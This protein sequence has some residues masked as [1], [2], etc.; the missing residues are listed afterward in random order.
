MGWLFSHRTRE[1]LIAER[2]EDV[3]TNSGTRTVLEHHLVDDVL[4]SLVRL[5]P[6]SSTAIPGVAAGEACVVIFCDLIDC[7]RGLWGSKTL[8]EGMGPFYW[9]CPL[10][11][12]DQA[13]HGIN[14]E[15]R[16]GVRHYHAAR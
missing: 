3:V 11:F 15:W 14:P 2:I 4:W 9:S 10:H 12:L 8:K 5:V 1:A 13:T 7:S 16:E 6:N